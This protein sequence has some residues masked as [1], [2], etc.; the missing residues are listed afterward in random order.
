M[1]NE[2]TLSRCPPGKTFLE[3]TKSPENGYSAVTLLDASDEANCE[4]STVEIASSIKS[5][6]TLPVVHCDGYKYDF[7]LDGGVRRDSHRWRVCTIAMVGRVRFLITPCWNRLR[8]VLHLLATR[9]VHIE[10]ILIL[11]LLIGVRFI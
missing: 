5:D 3:T 7:D 10:R 6:L 1:S 9:M 11:L 8:E 4:N 2:P